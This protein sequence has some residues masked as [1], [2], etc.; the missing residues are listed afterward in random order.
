VEQ[1]AAAVE[2][3]SASIDSVASVSSARREHAEKLRKATERGSHAVSTTEKMI[4]D[5]SGSVTAVHTMI[6]VIN[7]IAA[8]TNLLAMN[9]AIEA[10]HAGASGKGFA[11][12]A[13]EIRKLAE[14]TA[15][16]ASG[17]SSRLTELVDRIA[18][19]RS[20]SNETDSAF[21]EI[22]TGVSEVVDAFSEITG[23]T[24]ELSAGAREIVTAT[25]SLRST[26]AEISGSTTEMR[27]AAGDINTLI[28]QT[29]ETADETRESMAV[30]S[31]ASQNV[32]GVTNRVTALSTENNDQV[33]RL[34]DRIRKEKKD[35]DVQEA[36]EARERL[37]V[38]R[39]ILSHL[40]W[41][42]RLRTY[43]DDRGTSGKSAITDRDGGEL[44]QWLAVEGKTVVTDPPVYKEL[45]QNH[46]QSY[47]LAG[48]IAGLVAEIQDNRTEGGA[49][50]SVAAV[51][52][53]FTRVLSLSQRVIEILTSYQSGSFVRWS[54]DYSVEVELF[55]RHH[56][57]LFKL[58]GNLYTAMKNG[59]TGDDLTGVIDSLLDYTNYHFGVEEDAME[60][61]A[62]PGCDHQKKQHAHLV[63]SIKDLRADMESGKAFVAVDVMEFLRDWLTKHIKGCDKLYAEFFRDKDLAYLLEKDAS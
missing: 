37:L 6:D 63:Q 39:I 1:S 61:F 54:K 15:Q 21:R 58:I 11:V 5:V 23:S 32:T 51:E 62:Y 29:R 25:E 56:Q 9:A 22:E 57:K 40:S 46:R 55:D 19:A 60:R 13:A 38:S 26:S 18:E 30:I 7:D 35:S 43:I 4:E 44:G 33:L 53:R 45:V 27:N 3:M 41:V 2:Q 17:I 20:A 59:I 24:A 12:V 48:E 31:S 42:G 28:V 8:R 14:S 49:V 16:N 52:E 36:G 50:A 10:A 34:I 47:D